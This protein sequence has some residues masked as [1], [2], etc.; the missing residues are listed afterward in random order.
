MITGNEA[1]KAANTLIRY[2]K[3]QHCVGCA[4][5]MFC[6][7]S[8]DMPFSCCDMLLDTVE[9]LHACECRKI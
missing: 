8:C 6:G 5:E 9:A 4:I 1:R 3:E 7:D 2:C